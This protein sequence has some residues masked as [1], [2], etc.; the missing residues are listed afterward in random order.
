MVMKLLHAIKRVRSQGVNCL[1]QKLQNVLNTVSMKIRRSETVLLRKLAEKSKPDELLKNTRE[2]LGSIAYVEGNPLTKTEISINVDTWF[3]AIGGGA[4]I[5]IAPAALPAALQTQIPV[6]LLSLMDYFGGFNRLHSI[7]PV[8]GGWFPDN[9]DTIGIFGSGDFNAGGF[10]PLGFLAANAMQ[11]DMFLGYY[12]VAVGVPAF[13]AI[14]RIRCNNVSYGT[15]IKSFV[16]DLIT[17]SVLRYVVA[18]ADINQFLN[19]IIF[20]Y[21]TLFGKVFTDSVDP[22]M[23]VKPDDFQEQISDIP[24]NLPIDKAILI[25]TQISTFCQHFSWTLFVSK[26][27]PLTHKK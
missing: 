13:K 18:L 25:G 21:Q 17:I 4:P 1:R 6:Y 20:G 27:E 12:D 2:G 14:I 3:V 23:Y 5:I 7:C 22:R 16:S 10:L 15:F 26:V 19:P 9:G 8:G 24:I 11:G